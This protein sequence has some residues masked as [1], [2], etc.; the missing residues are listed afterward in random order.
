MI[1]VSAPGKIH[2]LGE[3]AIVFGKPAILAAINQRCFVSLNANETG[4]IKTFSR[5]LTKSKKEFDLIEIVLSETFKFFKKPKSLGFDLEIDS[6]IPVGCG[7]G[8]SAAVSVSVIGALFLLLGKNLDKNKINKIAYLAEQK[9]HG[10]PSGGDNSTVTYG[11]LVWFRKE[12]EDLK[13][14]QPLPFPLPKNLARNFVLIDTGRPK[15]T[16]GEMI[17]SVKKLLGKRPKWTEGIFNDQEKQVKKLLQALKENDEP[18]LKEAIRH[19]ERNLEKLGVIGGLAHDLI[20]EVEDLGGV[21]K[22]C[23]AGGTKDRSG[24]LLAYFQN[25]EVCVNLAKNIG[26]SSYSVTL[27]EEGVRQ[28]N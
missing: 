11:G 22:I 13:I 28:E 9:I 10:F 25:P 21:A 5:Q 14:I 8:S 3:H 17:A 15:E 7:L 20:R 16:T 4:K 19:G 23:G 2:L 27:G 18:L 1:K 24:V 12:S 26:L 6:K